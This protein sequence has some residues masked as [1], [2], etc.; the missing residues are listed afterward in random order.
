MKELV[1]SVFAVIVLS[2]IFNSVGIWLG[3]LPDLPPYPYGSSISEIKNSGSEFGTKREDFCYPEINLTNGKRPSCYITEITEKGDRGA[4][5][6]PLGA[7][8]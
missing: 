8:N 7:N 6:F 4:A 1:I 3:V 2:C 5:E